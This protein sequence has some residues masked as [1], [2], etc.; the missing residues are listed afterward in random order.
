MNGSQKEY[1]DG[2]ISDLSDRPIVLTTLHGGFCIVPYVW[3]TQGLVMRTQ[4]IVNGL[5]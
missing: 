4:N 5:L 1:E 3:Y 2:Y